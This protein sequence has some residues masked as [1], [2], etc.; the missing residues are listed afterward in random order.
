MVAVEF[1]FHTVLTTT[2]SLDYTV[3]NW[4]DS[5][6]FCSHPVGACVQ[7][8]TT[9][10]GMML[11]TITHTFSPLSETGLPTPNITCFDNSTLQVRGLVANPGMLY[12]FLGRARAVNSN[13]TAS[14]SCNPSPSSS[15]G[16]TNA[17]LTISGASESWFTW[18][19]GTEYDQDA[20][21]QAHDF[22]F[23]G[24][25]PH[26]S[27]SSLLV[28]ATSP[29]FTYASIL[30]AHTNDFTNVISPFALSL[31]QTP[32]LS[33]STDQLVA[34]YETDVGDAYLEWLLF[35][36]GRYMLASSARGLLP[37]NLQGK[38]AKDARNMWS[39]GWCL[40]F[41]PLRI[42]LTKEFPEG[43]LS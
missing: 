28:S 32:N 26:A 3:L 7:H 40:Q 33:N 8:L 43:R 14:I 37:A 27:L 4:C 38:W 35:N 24:P 18:V 12:E 13:G 34:A 6:S 21:D 11:P 25:D 39:S 31:G 10:S 19:G 41:H 29:N 5:D 22:T 17:T 9:N 15:T 20:G 36:Y 16:M 30:S 2:L 42:V 23:R 1:Y